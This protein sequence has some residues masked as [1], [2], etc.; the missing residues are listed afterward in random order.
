M[1]IDARKF[2]YSTS[3]TPDE[4]KWLERDKSFT[5]E[6]YKKWFD[7]NVDHV[8]S[9]LWK[10]DDIGMVE[11]VGAFVKLLKEAEFTY[12]LGA[13]QSAIALVGVCAE[14]LCRF[15]ATLAGRPLDTVTQNDRI[16]E[17]AA[18]GLLTKDIANNLHDIRKL[19]NDCL[20]FKEGFKIKSTS[21]LELDA[22]LA[23]NK[24]KNI[25]AVLI[26]ANDWKNLNLSNLS[27]AVSAM[28]DSAG[29]LGVANTETIAI[30]VRNMFA[31][32]TGID[33]SLDLG[34]GERRQS[35]IFDVLEVDL[36]WSPPEI[37]LRPMGQPFVVVVD[38]AD[39]DIEIIRLLALAEGD[40][41]WAVIT[42][43][44]NGLGMT[45]EWRFMTAPVKL[46]DA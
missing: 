26:G 17:L 33:L 6:A 4:E 35:A 12:S 19:R 30:G 1:Y 14:D 13:Y 16:N 39:E 31:Q 20:H 42:S 23:V 15:F 44:T 5:R 38:L 34:G 7:E 9:R 10:I 40:R 8:V 28:A 21:Q 27:D 46:T 29:E 11:K 36:V 41:I 45:D 24:I 2:N 25:Y 43:K 37:T 3:T 18:S 32:A 22:L